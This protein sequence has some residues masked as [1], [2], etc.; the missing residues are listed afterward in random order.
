[1]VLAVHDFL[2]VEPDLTVRDTDSL[3]AYRAR[4]LHLAAR[5]VTAEVA[6]AAMATAS[7]R[8]IEAFLADH[9]GDAEASRAAQLMTAG[10]GG[11]RRATI[12]LAMN[13]LVEESQSRACCR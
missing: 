1:M 13:S 9:L 11:S 7:Y 8:S 4:L 6:V 2:E 10:S 3:L 5:C 12:A